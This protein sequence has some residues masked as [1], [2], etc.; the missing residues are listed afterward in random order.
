MAQVILE[1]TQFGEAIHKSMESN[2]I[3]NMPLNYQEARIYSFYQSC[4]TMIGLDNAPTHLAVQP[5]IDEEWTFP[6]DPRV[7]QMNRKA[8]MA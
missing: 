1:D 2:G 7:A 4:D 3:K 5:A 6:D 8:A